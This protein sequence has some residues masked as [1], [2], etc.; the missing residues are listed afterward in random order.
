[1]SSR[2]AAHKVREVR[3]Y[4]ITG[5]VQGVGFRWWTRGEAERLGVVG[6]VRNEA[7]GSV[8]V[9]AAASA[10]GLARFEEALW[11]GPTLAAVECVERIAPR[12]RPE[13]SGFIVEHQG[14]TPEGEAARS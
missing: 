13:G 6:S 1:V 11:R 5:K 3:S 14:R 4:R 2:G 7:D 12:A 9:V 8:R 10:E